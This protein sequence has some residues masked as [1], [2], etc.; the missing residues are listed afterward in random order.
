MK[1]SA[2]SQKLARRTQLPAAE[3]ADALDSIVNDLLRRLKAGDKVTWPGLGTFSP[4][5]KRIEFV[6][7]ARAAARPAVRRKRA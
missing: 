2:F 3:A 1:K 5:G 7:E 6:A 4:E